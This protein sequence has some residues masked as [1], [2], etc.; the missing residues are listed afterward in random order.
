MNER[1]FSIE[2]PPV[3]EHFIDARE[4]AL[5]LIQ[6]GE[7]QRRGFPRAA[8]LAI[9]AAL[10]LTMGA[11]AAV[12]RF[13][14]L[15][16]LD[17]SRMSAP[18]GAEDAFVTDLGGTEGE[19]YTASVEEAYF[20]GVNFMLIVRY[21]VK[22]PQDALFVNSLSGYW[23]D[24]EG[25]YRVGMICE[26]QGPEDPWQTLSE[27]EDAHGGTRARISAI[28]PS[29][30][31]DGE[32]WGGSGYAFHQPDGSLIHVLQG[33]F[34]QPKENPITMS[35]RCGAVPA[36]TEKPTEYE[37]IAVALRPSETVWQ[38]EYVPE[39]EGEG[40]KVES[41][42]ITAGKMLMRAEGVYSCQPGVLPEHDYGTIVI[43]D[44]GGNDIPVPGGGGGEITPLPD[45]SVR[46]KWSMTLLTTDGCPDTLHLYLG[47]DGELPLGPIECRLAE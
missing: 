25:F 16:F 34:D 28:E 11:A 21:E 6:R 37:E 41:L 18:E 33:A 9:I 45:G 31:I 36:G 42:R 47:R 5:V 12:N 27:Y 30:F 17:W 35:V 7:A 23:R 43:K 2:A 1:E 10:L 39:A 15:D 32:S 19:L 46:V 40:W 38:V 4:R 26:L 44:A 24:D 14:I 8:V 20:D 3:P 13:G 29:M 22:N